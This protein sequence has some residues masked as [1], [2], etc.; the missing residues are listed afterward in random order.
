MLPTLIESR[1]TIPPSVGASGSPPARSWR[2]RGVASVCAHF[3]FSC[4]T[5]RSLSTSVR[6]A[7]AYSSAAVASDHPAWPAVLG[8]FGLCARESGASEKVNRVRGATG[9]GVE[10]RE[11]QRSLRVATDT[12]PE[13]RRVIGKGRRVTSDQFSVARGGAVTPH[14][15]FVSLSGFAQDAGELRGIVGIVGGDRQRPQPG[16][17]G[18]GIAEGGVGLGEMPLGWCIS[19]HPLRG[20]SKP[21]SG[22]LGVV[23]AQPHP[24]ALKIKLRERKRCNASIARTTLC[25]Q[26]FGGRRFPSLSVEHRQ[27]ANRVEIRPSLG[28]RSGQRERFIES[29]GC[30]EDR[31]ALGVHLMRIHPEPLRLFEIGQAIHETMKVGASPGP[32]QQS[33]AVL[34]RIA[35]K[36]LRQRRSVFGVGD[37]T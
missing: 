34:W 32:C 14:T 7:G 37:A 5:G 29:S 31:D 8:R 11:S 28:S 36:L 27:R 9:F 25:E 20:G 12:E 19:W 22:T 10:S 21:A 1:T 6:D 18:I 2:C 17:R 4:R 35:D 15:G 3:A 33:R 24:A 30:L 13:F 16:D 23:P 26:R